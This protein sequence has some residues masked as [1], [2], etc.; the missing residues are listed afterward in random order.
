MASSNVVNADSVAPDW[1]CITARLPKAHARCSDKTSAFEDDGSSQI[2]I[3]S[4]ADSMAAGRS[5]TSH[6]ARA[7]LFRA[8][9][10]SVTQLPGIR[11]SMVLK[12]FTASLIDLRASSNRFML[13]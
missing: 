9:D 10:N 11:C 13:D 8:S 4:L 1:L 5:P 2:L 12:C 3:A 7:C 6:L